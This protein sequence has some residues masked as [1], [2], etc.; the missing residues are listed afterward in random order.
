VQKI[1]NSLSSQSEPTSTKLE[2]PEDA[3]SSVLHLQQQQDVEVIPEPAEVIDITDSKIETSIPQGQLIANQIQEEIWSEDIDEG[4]VSDIESDN[5][6]SL[7]DV[8][9]EVSDTETEFDPESD[10]AEEE[11]ENLTFELEEKNSLDDVK[12]QGK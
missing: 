10:L 3:S 4:Y 8:I 9:E 11:I 1:R 6:V 2:E 5:D 12:N 7:N